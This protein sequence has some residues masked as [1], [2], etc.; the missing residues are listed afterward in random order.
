MRQQREG[1]RGPLC[2]HGQ[3]RCIAATPGPAPSDG[4]GDH[5]EAPACALCRGA[6][7]RRARTQPPQ[8][9]RG[10]EHAGQ[11]GEHLQ[12]A[13]LDPPARGRHGGHCQTR[14]GPPSSPGRATSGSVD[15]PS[16]ATC[17]DRAALMTFCR[18][19]LVSCIQVNGFP[20]HL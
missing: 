12:A 17:A 3:A 5:R 16:A 6:P 18:R 11:R 2:A 9:R 8:G 1:H 19:W 14:A 20:L 10:G 4:G 15:A 7:H 13:L